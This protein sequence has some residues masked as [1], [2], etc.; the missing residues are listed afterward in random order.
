MVFSRYTLRQHIA[1]GLTLVS[2]I[3]LWLGVTL[4]I[5]HI[6]LGTHIDAQISQLDLAVLD[7]TQ[8]ILQTVGDL[9]RHNNKFVTAMIL[10]F[11]IGVPILKG[12]ASLWL[13]YFSDAHRWRRACRRGLHYI[14]KWSMA[15]VFIVAV[16]LAYLSTHSNVQRQS[17]TLSAFGFSLNVSFETLLDSSLRDGFYYFFAYCMTSMI[18]TSLVNDEETI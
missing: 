7:K 10:L 2:F 5:L 13:I 12:V 1:G 14:S 17:T 18:A 4:P 15:D 9:W 6:H 16:F 11:S 8:S 3:L